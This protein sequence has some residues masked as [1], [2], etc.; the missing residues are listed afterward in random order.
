MPRVPTSLISV[1]LLTTKR[2]RPKWP[3][4]NLMSLLTKM[5]ATSVALWLG[6]TSL[7]V[8]ADV[9]PDGLSAVIFR[10]R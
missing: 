3:S 2:R 9:R 7:A 4:G 8:I 6:A 5:T 1:R 10:L